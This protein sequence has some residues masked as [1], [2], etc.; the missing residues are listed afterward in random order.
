VVVLISTFRCGPTPARLRYLKERV[1]VSRRTVVRWRSWWC[2]QLIDTPFWR[3]AA[4]GLI[5]PLQHSELPA[6]LLER[7]AGRLFD[8][9][10][11]LLRFIAPI[12]TTSDTVHG[13]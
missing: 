2:E 12:T 6:S 4:A 13:M 1:G 7:F 10:V 9:L 3:A 11:S 8:R 5:P